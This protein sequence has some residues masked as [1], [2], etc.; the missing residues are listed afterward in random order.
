MSI[1]LKAKGDNWVRSS[2]AISKAKKDLQQKRERGEKITQQEMKERAITEGKKQLLDALLE[3]LKDGDFFGALTS[4]GK[5]MNTIADKEKNYTEVLKTYLYSNVNNEGVHRVMVDIK[6]EELAA[7]NDYVA[8]KMQGDQQ[9]EYLKTLD[10]L[11]II[12]PKVRRYNVCR[13]RTDHT[14]TVKRANGLSLI[15]I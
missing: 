15:H 7:L 9:A 5:R 14:R 4:A 10:F 13:R 2:K 12:A 3:A 1:R 11:D 6:Q 8:C